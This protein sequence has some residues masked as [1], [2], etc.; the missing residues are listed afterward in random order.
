ML[1][2]LPDGWRWLQTKTTKRQQQQQ[3]KKKKI[4]KQK[5]GNVTL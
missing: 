5:K 2:P 4:K 3:N 1:Q